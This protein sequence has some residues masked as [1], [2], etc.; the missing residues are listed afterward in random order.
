MKRYLKI[1]PRNQ[2]VECFMIFMDY[3][4]N[5]TDNST[6]TSFDCFN[7]GVSF[8]KKL[9]RAHSGLQTVLPSLCER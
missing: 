1:R 3:L 2:K 9:N 7:P 4:T 8:G 6:A 5:P